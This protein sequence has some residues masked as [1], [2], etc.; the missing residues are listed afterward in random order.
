MRPTFP[1][2]ENTPFAFS[3]Y[4][5]AGVIAWSLFAEI[6]GRMNEVFLENGNLIKKLIFRVFV[7]R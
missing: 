6:L 2:H 3:I 4:L 7:Y 1:G 5:C